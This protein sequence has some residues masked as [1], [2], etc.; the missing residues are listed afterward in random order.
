MVV[1]FAYLNQAFVMYLSFL[2]SIRGE[3]VCIAHY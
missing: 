2:S 1:V 3:W